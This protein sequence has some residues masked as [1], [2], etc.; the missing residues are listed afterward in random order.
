ARTAVGEIAGAA[1]GATDVDG[2]AAAGGV[3]KV[4]RDLD[5]LVP[6]F[7]KRLE[8][9]ISR[10]ESE[11]GHQ[12]TIV[13][14][15]RSQERQNY[16]FEQGRSRPGQVVTWTKNSNHLTGRAADVLIDGTY[17]NAAGYAR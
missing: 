2:A 9:V 1:A 10:M 15:V 7:R 4:D 3:R 8:R 11:F 12:V 5:E 17:D 16:L 13:E 14:A 6:E